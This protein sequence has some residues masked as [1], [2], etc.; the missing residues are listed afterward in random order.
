MDIENMKKDWQQD[1]FAGQHQ[2]APYLQAQNQRKHRQTFQRLRLRLIIEA[3]L[4]TLLLLLAYDF[5]DG[6]KRAL[7]TYGLLWAGG[8]AWVVNHL[9]LFRLSRTVLDATTVKANLQNLR[10]RY[11]QQAWLGPLLLILF[12]GALMSFLLSGLD[13][14]GRA[15]WIIGGMSLGILVGAALN[16]QYW[17][18]RARNLTDLLAAW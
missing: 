3:S 16:R 12:Q 6:E 8:L 14:T 1:S 9:R 17:L 11:Q 13:L 4:I 18:R 15:G 2:S 10:M 5:F 7:W